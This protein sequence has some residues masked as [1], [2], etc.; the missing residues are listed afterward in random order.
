ML[1]DL[2]PRRNGPFCAVNCA[3]IPHELLESELF[4]VEKFAVTGVAQRAGL[5]EQA[6]RGTL[7]LD[8]IA[9]MELPLQAKLLRV[10]QSKTFYRVGG[11]KP[12]TVDVRIVAATNREPA[13][14]IADNKLRLDVFHRL[15]QLSIRLPPLAAHREDISDIARGILAKYSPDFP[16]A[17]SEFAEDAMGKLQAYSYPGGVRELEN[18]IIE[19]MALATQDGSA[20]LELCHLR[21]EVRNPSPAADLAEHAPDIDPAAAERQATI[22]ALSSSEGRV[23]LAARKLGIGERG[24]RERMK[25]L[26]IPKP[27]QHSAVTQ[28]D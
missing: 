25:R 20:N 23:S 5:F 4:G 3:A 18:I 7:F 24:L 6:N 13:Q 8:E 17:F 27:S 16:R 12:V 19:A 22:D 11:N 26:N 9:E 14:A 15:N 21:L 10:L 1:H 2:S 28:E